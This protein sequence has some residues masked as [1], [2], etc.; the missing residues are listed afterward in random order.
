MT[1]PD[2]IKGLMVLISVASALA[3][4]AGRFRH[5]IKKIPIK[6]H[7]RLA[8]SV[9]TYGLDF[10]KAIFRKRIVEPMAPPSPSFLTPWV[11]LVNLLFAFIL[12]D[13]YVGY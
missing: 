3:V 11:K 7:G 8:F 12:G 4:T 2:R 10:L 6:K 5:Y 13:K 1:D 9:F